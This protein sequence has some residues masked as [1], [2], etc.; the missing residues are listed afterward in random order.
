M[1]KYIILLLLLIISTTACTQNS[2]SVGSS[3]NADYVEETN[4]IYVDSE[5]SEQIKTTEEQISYIVENAQCGE[6][7][8][9]LDQNGY[10]QIWGQGDYDIKNIGWHEYYYDIK[11]IKVSVSGIT[12]TQ[13]MFLDC[14]NVTEIDLSELDTEYVTNMSSMFAVCESLKDIDLSN[15]K[16]SKVT[17]MGGM[18][19]RCCNLQEIDVRSFDTSNVL[20]T[21]YMFATCIY[22]TKIDMG[23]FDMSNVQSAEGMFMDCEN[24]EDLGGFDYNY[25][26]LNDTM[27]AGCSKLNVDYSNY[28]S[29]IVEYIVEPTQSGDLMWS[30]DVNGHLEIWGEGDYEHQSIEYYVGRQSYICKGPLWCS[31][32]YAYRISSVTVSV[33]GITSTENMFISCEMNEI[34]LTNLNTSNVTNMHGMFNRCGGLKNIDLSNFDTTNVTDMSCMFMYCWNLNNLDLSNFNTSNVK[35]AASMFRECTALYDLKINESDFN[36]IRNEKDV[37]K[38]CP[39]LE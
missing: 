29:E 20:D 30:L 37:F 3:G 39:Y 12:S 8:W 14:L 24:L 38:D 17:D 18:F 4:E 6:L 13:D 33:S 34:D 19:N 35:N 1:K 7:M 23:N 31:E 10:L 36:N 15:F 32:E 5:S 11:K 28:E 9:S 22:T 27:Y 21:S 26:H 25:W 16:T 2:A